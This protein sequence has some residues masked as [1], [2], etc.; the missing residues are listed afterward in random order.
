MK[1]SNLL[2]FAILISVFT[3]SE[4]SLAQFNREYRGRDHGDY[5]G[6]WG[7]GHHG[8]GR[9]RPP[10]P[11]PYYPQPRPPY[12]PPPYYPP[13]VYPAYNPCQATYVGR[14]ST[15]FDSQI[16]LTQTG[17]NSISWMN[18]YQ[19]AVYYGQGSCF[20][21]SNGF[22][23]IQVTVN[24]VQPFSFTGSIDQSGHFVGSIFSHNVTF[25]GYRIR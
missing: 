25:D 9:H 17:Y 7:R 12:N 15:G 13:P 18:T 19:G 21:N 10:V 5:R 3:F 6:G 2:I 11:P 1:P 20:V 8:G 14:M 24:G 23:S 4:L 16:T 22:A